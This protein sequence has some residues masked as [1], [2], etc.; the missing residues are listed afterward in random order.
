MSECPLCK[1][2]KLTEWYYEDPDGRFVILD[3]KTCGV[4]MAV[5]REHTMDVDV[6]LRFEMCEQLAKVAF[7]KYQ[8]DWF[9]SAVPRSIPDHFHA[10]V[11]PTREAE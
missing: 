5:L 1:L 8:F 11:R 6:D 2:E 3:C 9:L 10:H 7:Q 4:P